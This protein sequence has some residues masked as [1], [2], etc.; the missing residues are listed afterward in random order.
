MRCAREFTAYSAGNRIEISG[1]GEQRWVFKFELSI[2]NR[3][4]PPGTIPGGF[5]VVGTARFRARAA[6][7]VRT[8][9][10][11]DRR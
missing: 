4:R 3:P 5:F 1:G 9:E 10:R 6:A 11:M 2:F 7:P 8:P